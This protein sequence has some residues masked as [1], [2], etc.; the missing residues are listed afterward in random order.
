MSGVKDS[1]SRAEASRARTWGLLMLFA[2]GGAVLS[3]RRAEAA[4]AFTATNDIA[5]DVEPGLPLLFSG[6]VN[7][8]NVYWS[9][10][11]DANPANFRRADIERA[12]STVLATPYFDRMCQYGVGGFQF[13]GSAQAAGICGSSPGAVTS[14]PQLL[15]FMS[16]EEYTPFTGVP[17]SIG[18]P[19]PVTCALCGIG[20]IDCFNI[21]EPLCTLTP[22]P[23]GN[24]VYILF[25]PK[26]TTIN[27]FG[28][29][30]CSNYSA[31]HFQIPSRGIFSLLPPFILPGTQGRPL[32]LAI[33][34]T[35]CFGSV[36]SLMGA[37]THEV[38]EAASDPLPLAHWLDESSGNRS[39]RLDPSHI[40]TLLTTGEIA[41]ICNN[42]SVTFTGADGTTVELADYW[43][44]HDNQCRSLDVPPTITC[45]NCASGGPSSALTLGLLVLG[46]LVRR[47]RHQGPD[48]RPPGRHARTG[49]D[50]HRT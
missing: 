22:N 10:D 24:R 25:L 31:F 27:D 29:T 45:Q 20:P 50:L 36:A 4:C 42:R 41:D 43:S 15:S 33:I 38:V 30:S 13:E 23:T 5:L 6:K 8:F 34:P 44:N 39:N 47:R 1:R 7:L 32:N 18:L 14:T 37:V 48:G 19:N 16:C 3:A 2:V 12:M 49:V 11:W 26:G 21:A 40:E 28:R 9:A 46:L 35:D 17:T